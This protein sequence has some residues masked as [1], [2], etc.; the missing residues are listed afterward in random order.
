MGSHP[1]WNG[2][3]YPD[4]LVVYPP[5]VA[6]DELDEYLEDKEE[7]DKNGWPYA[8]VIAPDF[9]HKEDVSGGPPY[10]VAVPATTNDPPLDY[11][12]RGISFVEYLEL[13]LQYGGFPGLEECDNHNWPLESIV[14]KGG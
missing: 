11:E 13:S 1:E 4:P 14:G 12:E 8:I 10:S 6:L 2:C 7:R 9:Y 3:D 5:S